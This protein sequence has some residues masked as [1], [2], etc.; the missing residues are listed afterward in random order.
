MKR[1]EYLAPQSLAEA[2]EMLYDRLEAIPP[3]TYALCLPIPSP[4]SLNSVTLF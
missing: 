3:A 1:F 4:A 2:L